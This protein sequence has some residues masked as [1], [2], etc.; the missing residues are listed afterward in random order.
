MRTREGT[1]IAVVLQIIEEKFK[2][3]DSF[4]KSYVIEQIKKRIN[5]TKLVNKVMF[6]HEKSN[7]GIVN[8]NRGAAKCFRDA[9]RAMKPLYIIGKDGF[10]TR[11]P[12]E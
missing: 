1:A 11:R 7:D 12:S 8:I 6:N 10:I 9:G 2:E 4:H 3:R 5:P